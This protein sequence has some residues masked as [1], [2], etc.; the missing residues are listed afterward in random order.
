M[1][2]NQNIAEYGK[3]TQFTSGCEAVENGKKGGIA[4]GKVRSIKAQQQKRL[5]ELMNMAMK[6]GE[7]TK[8]KNLSQAK[9]ANL[10]VSDQMLIKLITEALKG[11]LK[12]YELLLRMLGWDQPEPQEATQ[13]YSNGFMDAL[14]NTAAEVWAN[15]D[16]APEKE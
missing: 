6:D 2:G 8:I 3:N 1:A 16:E 14:N 11:N 10:T 15:E 4:S 12:A 7:K 9:G 13:E 5:R